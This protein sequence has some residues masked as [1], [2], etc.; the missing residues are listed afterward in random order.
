M[1]QHRLGVE[2]VGHAVEGQRVVDAREQLRGFR[3]EGA[4]PDQSGLGDVG[5]DVDDDQPLDTLR[6]L[7]RKGDRHAPAHRQPDDRGPRD[8][9]GV[10]ERGQVG[11]QRRHRVVR[12]GRWVGIAVAA[13]IEGE[14]TIARGERGRFLVPGPRVAGHPVQHDQRGRR[15]RAPF[16]IVKPPALQYDRSILVHNRF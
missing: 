10:G 13:L 6:R 2:R 9:Q 4:D 7:A 14:H 11:R 8:P 15:R 12:V 5:P 16:R 3:H 1:E